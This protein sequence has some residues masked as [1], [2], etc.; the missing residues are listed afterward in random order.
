MAL[1]KTKETALKHLQAG[2]CFRNK[3]FELFRNDRDVLM[4]ALAHDKTSTIPSHFQNDA[5]LAEIL[6]KGR[7][8]VKPDDCYQV[9]SVGRVLL[10]DVDFMLE[11]FKSQRHP[12]SRTNIFLLC[13]DKVKTNKAICLYLVKQ[14]ISAILFIPDTMKKDYEVLEAFCESLKYSYFAMRGDQTS[15]LKSLGLPDLEANELRQYLQAEQLK[16]SLDARL[17]TKEETKRSVKI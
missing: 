12:V 5:E 1:Y 9:L 17:S 11:V 10:D 3:G 4:V 16:N 6:F 2:K 8:F 14:W 13:S 15:I 7:Y